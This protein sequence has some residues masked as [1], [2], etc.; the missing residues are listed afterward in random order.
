[1]NMNQLLEKLSGIETAEGR[2]QDY[3]PGQRARYDE[4][5]E[6]EVPVAPEVKKDFHLKDTKTGKILSKDGQRSVFSSKRHAEAVAAKL[7]FGSWEAVPVETAEKGVAEGSGGVSVRSWANQVRKDHGSDIKFFNRKEGGG[8]VDSVI[9]KNSQGETVGVYN[10]KTGFPTVFEPKQGVTEGLENTSI[11]QQMARDGITY[12][13]EK[14]DELIGLMSQYMKKNGMSS[15]QIRY[16]LS[17]DEDFISDQ[18]SE[19]PRQGVT[20]GADEVSSLKQLAGVKEAVSSDELQ[21]LVDRYKTGDLDFDELRDQ[22]DSIERTDY[23][24]RQ[25][26]M[27]NPELRGQL[28]KDDDDWDELGEPDNDANDDPYL[29]NSAGIMEDDVQECMSGPPV[30][31]QHSPATISMTADSGEELSSMLKAIVQLAGMRSSDTISSPGGMVEPSMTDFDSGD[32]MRHILDRMH[33]ED[34]MQEYDNEPDPE[35]AGYSAN[36]PSGNDLHREKNQYPAAQ[37][38]DNAMAAK[39]EHL[40]KEYKTFLEESSK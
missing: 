27:G 33:D 36:V 14:E 13:P 39:F 30:S 32:S 6:P 1:M 2:W 26:E 4:P 21:D 38:G 17:Y 19:L 24:M 23:S 8:A 22:L 12:S 11:G 35:S 5:G 18:L 7:K 20:K 34:V 15:K 31:H 29:E 40:M 10:R 3:T 28:E 9:A 37:P 25:G 16:L